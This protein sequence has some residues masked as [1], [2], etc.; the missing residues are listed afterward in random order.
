MKRLILLFF[1][2]I[3]LLAF[4]QKNIE[5]QSLVWYGYFQKIE[6]NKK[7][8]IETEVQERHFINPTVQ[9]QL[10]IRPHLHRILGN[11]WEVSTGGCLFLQNPN[12]PKAVN[13]LTVPELR[14]HV[15]FT[16]NQKLK[17]FDLDYRY[18]TELRFYR[19]TDAD[20]TFLEDGYEFS[21]IR[22]RYRVQATVPIYKKNLKIKTS[23]ELH[24]NA[25]NK[26]TKNVFEQNRLYV[27]LSYTSSPS[28]TTD[29]GYMN[30]FQQRSDG[31]Y[32][33]RDILRFT[34]YHKIKNKHG[35]SIKRPG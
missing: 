3:P 34:V 30:W 33:S 12:D 5:N 9:H 14:P 24:I 13:K 1:A 26:I 7:W 8:Y 32:F 2:I 6:L 21:N 4:S 16:Y 18:R 27:G 31:N 11:G 35:K 15:E 17:Y 23:N 10:L 20:R 22:F 28:L 19:N 29:I 25:G